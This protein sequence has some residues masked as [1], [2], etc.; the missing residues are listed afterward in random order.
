[1]KSSK[2]IV[3]V[4]IEGDTPM[5]RSDAYGKF[6]KR[7][8]IATPTLGTVRM[9]WVQGRFG[10]TISCNFSLVDWH[11][12]MNPYQPVGFQLAD[13]ENL[14]VKAFIEG[15]FQWFLS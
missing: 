15:G 7:F 5:T 3:Q 11:S 12:F 10:Q 8:F 9:E 2:K 1:M 4:P 13:A 6:N 14:A